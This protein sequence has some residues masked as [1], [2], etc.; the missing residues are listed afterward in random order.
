MALEIS[1]LSF[2]SEHS[3]KYITP[4]FDLDPLV[5]QLKGLFR[6][7]IRWQVLNGIISRSLEELTN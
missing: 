3:E 1:S 6:Y 7:K 5:K 4:S 2:I